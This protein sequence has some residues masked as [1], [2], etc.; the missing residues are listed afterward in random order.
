M[1][2]LQPKCFLLAEFRAGSEIS[3][4]DIQK[5]LQ[6]LYEYNVMLMENMNIAQSMINALT[7][8]ASSSAAEKSNLALHDSSG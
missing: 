2:A 4:T 1:L 6:N 8:K 7:S 3:A 5:N